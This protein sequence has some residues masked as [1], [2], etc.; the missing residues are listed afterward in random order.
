MMGTKS[1]DGGASGVKG[2]SLA[3]ASDGHGLHRYK[4]FL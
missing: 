2:L 3:L 4:D 1:W